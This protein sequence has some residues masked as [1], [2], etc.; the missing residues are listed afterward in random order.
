MAFKLDLLL[1]EKAKKTTFEQLVIIR[2]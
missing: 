2:E 1:Q